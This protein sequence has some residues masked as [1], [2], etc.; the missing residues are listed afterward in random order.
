MAF[1]QP[2]HSVQKQRLTKSPR[3]RDKLSSSVTKRSYWMFAD[4]IEG[5][6]A[7]RIS[8][9]SEITA[10]TIPVTSKEFSDSWNNTTP[11]AVSSNTS[12]TE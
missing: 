11:I 4:L 10:N 3:L 9:T 8:R 6:Y 7:K 2:R 12:E 1:C 5:C